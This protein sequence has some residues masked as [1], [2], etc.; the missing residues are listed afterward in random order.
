MVGHKIKIYIDA[1]HNPGDFWMID[2]QVF[3]LMRG[4]RESLAGRVALLHMSPA[5]PAGD[6][7][8]KKT[9]SPDRRL[10]R[11]FGVIDK[12]SLKRGVGAIL[13]MAD[14]FSALDRENLIVPIWMI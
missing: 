10:T 2:S 1:H 8:I 5:V 14:H 12:S 9:S 13:C 7:R 3:R 11:V 4:V 6:R